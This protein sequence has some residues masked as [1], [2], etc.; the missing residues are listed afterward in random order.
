MIQALDQICLQKKS[1]NVD[2]R[3][4]AMANSVKK[5]VQ[6]FDINGNAFC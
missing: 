3:T 1:L 2:Y 6:V 4:A 5:V